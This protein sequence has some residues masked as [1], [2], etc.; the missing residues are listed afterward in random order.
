M[1][2]YHEKR[3]NEAVEGLV[4]CLPTGEPISITEVR[5]LLEEA[6]DIGEIHGYQAGN[7]DGYQAG[8]YDD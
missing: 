6:Y 2:E 8:K 1:S 3:K 5:K 4:K 7:F